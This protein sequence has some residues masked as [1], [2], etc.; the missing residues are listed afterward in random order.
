[1]ETVDSP[2]PIAGFEILKTVLIPDGLKAD[3]IKVVSKADESKP[4]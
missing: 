4:K 2:G 3:G 1:M